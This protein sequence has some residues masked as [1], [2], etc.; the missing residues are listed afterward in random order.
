MKQS[1]YLRELKENLESRVSIE[2][3]KDILSDYESFF[4]SGREEGKNDDEISEELGSPG[5]LGKSLLEEHSG[6]ESRQLDKHIT[7]PGRRL[8]AY[9]MDT[10]IAVVPALLVLLVIGRT[11]ALPF[12]LFLTYPSPGVG[13]SVYMS[14]STYTE[15]SSS[16]V[17]EIYVIGEDGTKVT[18]ASNLE[19]GS[20]AAKQS[21]WENG[22]KPSLITS[23]LASVGLLFYLIY[24]LVCTLI[25]KGQTVGKKLMHI[26]IRRSNTEL[27]TKGTIFYREFLGKTLINSIPLIPLISLLT[28]LFT[29]EH[30]ALHDMLADTI[31]TDV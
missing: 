18:N 16:G 23:I 24:S 29:K 9:A 14:Y 7:N 1:E 5:F 6:K 27:V 4:M 10:I 26:K 13:A 20:E 25:F 28:I 22:K 19:S 21:R 3:L 11:L 12:V 8:C 31:V 2:E 17:T 15:Y 30:K